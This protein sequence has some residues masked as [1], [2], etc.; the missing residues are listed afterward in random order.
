MEGMEG[1]EG[2]IVIGCQTKI[3]FKKNLEKK[4][5]RMG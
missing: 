4:S 2:Y 3:F 1:M 5:S